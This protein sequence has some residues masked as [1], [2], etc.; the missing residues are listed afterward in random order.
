MNDYTGAVTVGCPAET[1]DLP[2]LTLT[3]IAVG[4]HTNNAYLLRSK[5][6]GTQVLIGGANDP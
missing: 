6:T 3:E 4:P 5:T 1:R 2:A